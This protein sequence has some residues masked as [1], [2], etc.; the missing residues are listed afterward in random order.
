MSN[1]ARTGD[2]LL[3]EIDEA[4]RRILA[5]CG[6]DPDRVLQSYLDYQK[7]FADRLVNYSSKEPSR[8]RPEAA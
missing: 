5:E 1:R 2:P 6:N 4:R 3:D 8:D 7:Q